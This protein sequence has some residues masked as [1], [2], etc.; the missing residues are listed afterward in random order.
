MTSAED[1]EA[2]TKSRGEDFPTASQLKNIES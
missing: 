1:F 2:E